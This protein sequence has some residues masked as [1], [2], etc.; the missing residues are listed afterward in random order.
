MDESPT[1]AVGEAAVAADDGGAAAAVAADDELNAQNVPDGSGDTPCPL[2]NQ[3]GDDDSKSVA[4]AVSRG[5]VKTVTTFFDGDSVVDAALGGDVAEDTPEKEKRST[6]QHTDITPEQ[7]RLQARWKARNDAEHVGNIGWLFGNWG[8]RPGNPKMRAHLDEVL[9]K[10]PAMVIGLAECQEATEMVL[11]AVPATVT[12]APKAQAKSKFKS[13]PEFQYL[14]MRGNEDSSVLIAVRDQAG[15][16]LDL[17][18]VEK[19]RHG[20]TKHSP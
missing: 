8:K 14:T 19:L 1:T 7:K 12:A 2:G 17:L 4:S 11:R 20:Q 18:D 3:D 13:R 5:A 6:R 16:T 9:K 15:C 10:Q